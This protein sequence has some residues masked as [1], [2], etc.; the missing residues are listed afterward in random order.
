MQKAKSLFIVEEKK[1]ET[2]LGK[3]L[4]LGEIKEAEENLKLEKAN[5]TFDNPFLS[6][7]SSSFTPTVFKP[8]FVH[9]V[10]GRTT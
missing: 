2:N 5:S 10:R 6:V 4:D 1:E 8:F 3:D 9:S 7:K